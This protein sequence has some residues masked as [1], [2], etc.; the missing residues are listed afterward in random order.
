MYKPLSSAETSVILQSRIEGLEVGQVDVVKRLLRLEV[1][2]ELVTAAAQ[3]HTMLGT[4]D[5]QQQA[6]EAAKYDIITYLMKAKGLDYEV[7]LAI[8]NGTSAVRA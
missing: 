6:Y 1:P 5:D 4:P 2:K 7:A 8:A 3:A